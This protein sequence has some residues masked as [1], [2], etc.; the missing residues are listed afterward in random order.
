MDML[1]RLWKLDYDKFHSEE[2]VLLENRGV[3]VF[4]PLSPS[5]T[6]VQKFIMENF[7][8]GWTSEA[9]AGLYNNPVSLY[10]AA[11]NGE[12]LGFGCYDATGKGIF[13]PTGVKE[14]ER[15]KSI[16]KI[17]LY[18]CMEAMWNDGYAYSVIGSAGPEEFYSKFVD[19]KVIEDCQPGIYKRMI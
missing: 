12:I 14:S 13:G 6:K 16:G 19:A 1:V 8:E 9:T 7:G 17:I 4:R 5:F 10:V 3:S 2:K 18:R 15:G 11:K